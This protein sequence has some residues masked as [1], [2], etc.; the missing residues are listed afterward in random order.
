MVADDDMQ[1]I[2]LANDSQY[3]LGASI[4]TEDLEAEVQKKLS[5]IMYFGDVVDMWWLFRPKKSHC[6]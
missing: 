1:T 5:R 4:W 6:V 3:G 2:K